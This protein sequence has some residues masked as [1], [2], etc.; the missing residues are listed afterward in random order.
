MDIFRNE[1]IFWKITPNATLR[2]AVNKHFAVKNSFSP[3]K[4]INTFFSF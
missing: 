4:L 2:W 3:S 1:R